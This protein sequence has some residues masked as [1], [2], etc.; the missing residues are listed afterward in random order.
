MLGVLRANTKQN[1]TRT[2]ATIVEMA[3][4]RHRHYMARTRQYLRRLNGHTQQQ[5]GKQQCWSQLVSDTVGEI[6]YATTYSETIISEAARI[7]EIVD[8]IEDNDTW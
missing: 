4:K 3:P 1:W 6:S 8:A 2:Y 7:R 5:C